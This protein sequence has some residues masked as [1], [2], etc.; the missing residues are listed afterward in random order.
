MDSIAVIAIL[1]VFG[2]APMTVFGFILLLK[3]QKH[4][5]E[6]LR[7]KKEI[8][9][10]ELEKDAYKIKLL[11]EENRKYDRLIQDQSRN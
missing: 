8:L 11:E 1:S 10:L 7:Y 9:E 6:E 3:R 5:V 4:R 2:L